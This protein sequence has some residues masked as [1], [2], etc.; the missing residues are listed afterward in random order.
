M[1]TIVLLAQLLM[2]YNNSDHKAKQLEFV[3]HGQY[4]PSFIAYSHED[5]LNA[6]EKYDLVYD[7]E[8]L[9]CMTLKE[10]ETYQT[11]QGE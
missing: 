7:Y 4:N 11:R 6:C 5:M 3:N 9:S 10:W 2:A 1:I 8:S